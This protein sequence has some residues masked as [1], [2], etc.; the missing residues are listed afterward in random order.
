MASEEHR[1]GTPDQRDGI[2]WL[3]SWNQGALGN[4]F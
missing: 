3:A 4:D 1:S 2:V